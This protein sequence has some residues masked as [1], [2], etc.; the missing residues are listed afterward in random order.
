VFNTALLLG[1]LYFF[2]SFAQEQETISFKLQETQPHED[3]VNEVLEAMGWNMTVF[4]PLNNV[5]ILVNATTRL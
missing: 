5:T 2:S 3:E 1:A 4:Q